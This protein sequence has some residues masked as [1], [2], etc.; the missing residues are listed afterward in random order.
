MAAYVQLEHVQGDGTVIVPVVTM[1]FRNDDTSA[2]DTRSPITLPP[3]VE[4]NLAAAIAGQ[5]VSQG[6]TV[7][8]M[9]GTF[10][11]GDYAIVEAGT[12]R[13][14][15][16]QVA[17]DESGNLSAL[18]RLSHSI[19]TLLMKVTAAYSKNIRMNLI[20]APANSISNVR[21]SR[22]EKL[23]NGVYDQYRVNGSYV[24]GVNT[25]WISDASN[26]Y[27]PAPETPTLVYS[28]PAVANGPIPSLVEIQWLFTARQVPADITR[29]RQIEKFLMAAPTNYRWAWD[30]S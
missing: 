22:T 29:E 6:F 15:C 16:V 21:F 27:S 26:V 12:P 3:D 25:P 23:L 11:D 5:T 24:P 10:A 19:G 30:E 20:T 13:Q 9:A 14:E 8:A 17:V 28:G 4:A 2:A 7:N 18:F 1:R